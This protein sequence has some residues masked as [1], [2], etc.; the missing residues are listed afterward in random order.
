V[1]D[2][3]DADPRCEEMHQEILGLDR[4]VCLMRENT[5]IVLRERNIVYGE[6]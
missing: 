6:F 1:S 3:G 5:F 4:V 2:L